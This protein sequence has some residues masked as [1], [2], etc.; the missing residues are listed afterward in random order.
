MRKKPDTCGE[1]LEIIAYQDSWRTDDSKP[2]T[3]SWNYSKERFERPHLEAYKITLHQS[4][5]EGG[6]VKKRQWTVCTMSYYDICEY[7]WGECVAGS[8]SV[9]AEKV[10]IDPSELCRLIDSKLEPLRK[11]IEAEFHQSPEYIARTEHE[12][13][14]ADY[15]EKKAGFAANMRWTSMIMT[16][17]M[18]FLAL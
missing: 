12:R 5:R 13:I 16:V 7:W 6:K 15:A 2:F 10:G 8:E 9:L 4:Y 14:R 3:W 18:M 1:P 11:R 17:A